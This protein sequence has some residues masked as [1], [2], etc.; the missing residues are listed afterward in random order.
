MLQVFGHV[1]EGVLRPKRYPKHD[2]YLFSHLSSLNICPHF[3]KK[4]T[5]VVL[6]V[7]AL[8]FL[9]AFKSVRMPKNNCFE[10]ARGMFLKNLP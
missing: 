5:Y 7:T 9:K 6:H 8:T 1:G 2:C 4:K 10:K 3:F